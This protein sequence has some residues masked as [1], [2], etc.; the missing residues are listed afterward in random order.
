MTKKTIYLR[1]LTCMTYSVEVSETDQVI[2]LKKQLAERANL[3]MAQI[4]LIY[5]QR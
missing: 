4:R 2:N 5:N 3:D 1:M